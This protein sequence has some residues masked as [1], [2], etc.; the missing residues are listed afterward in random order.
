[1]VNRDEKIDE[2]QGGSP[3]APYTIS[4]VDIDLPPSLA[5]IAV[6][7]EGIEFQIRKDA[8]AVGI[9]EKVTLNNYDDFFWSGSLLDGEGSF[10][11]KYFDGAIA[12]NIEYHNYILR[13]PQRPKYFPKVQFVISALNV[14]NGAYRIN[15]VQLEKYDTDA[16]FCANMPQGEI[17]KNLPN[18]PPPPITDKNGIL[19]LAVLYT[20]EAYVKYKEASNQDELVLAHIKMSVEMANLAFENSGIHMRVRVVMTKRLDAACDLEVSCVENCIGPDSNQN[21]NWCKSNILKDFS[22]GD[23]FADDYQLTEEAG[24]DMVVLFG[25]YGTN[26]EFCGHG[27]FQED[28]N[29][30]PYLPAQYSV[31]M[32]SLEVRL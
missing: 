10:N 14:S 15:E 13:A 28:T 2:N 1:L 18:N 23:R 24:V 6:V 17:P 12:A 3:L 30:R 7:G 27:Y 31:I 22:S 5:G 4:F 20:P 8:F 11:L 26:P 29:T 9:I 32:V 19:D 25:I 16:D 21:T